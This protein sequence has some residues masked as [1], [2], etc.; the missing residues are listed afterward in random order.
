MVKRITSFDVARDAGVSRTT[1][2]L[3]LNHVENISINPATR[4]RVI[5]AAEKLNYHPNASGRRLVTG[6]SSTI[7]LVLHQSSDQIF[8]DAFLL[9]VMVGVEQA[10]AKHGY[11]VLLKPLDPAQTYDFP[12][13]INENHVDGILLSGP[14]QDD[15]EIIKHN[16]EGFPIMLMG[17]LAGSGIPF[18]DI[19]AIHGAI[20]A[21]RHL[22]NLG[23]R[24]IGLIT[25]AP[26]EYTS[27]QQRR[28]GFIEA[29]LEANIQPND[30]LIREGAFTP[31]SG[32]EAMTELL[33]SSE[34][35][36]AVFVTSDVVAIGAMQAIKKAHKRIPQ[37]IALV[38][39][40][41]IPMAAYFDPPLTTVRLPAYQLGWTAGERL[42][43]LILGEK[44]TE[45]GIFLDTELVIRT[46]T[47]GNPRGK[48]K[49]HPFKNLS[50]RR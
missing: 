28:Q 41:D 39:F 6:K 29:L 13:L 16:N 10:V 48:P 35:P 23:H 38:G 37:D 49:S 47:I 44:L 5:A 2:S 11:H 32:F 27:A 15:F 8:A 30:H 4:Q 7:G 18:V 22:I 12:Q 40:D 36:T 34:L 9:Q 31:A 24:H 17:Q 14:R 45:P 33:Q 3:V 26:L 25:N 43:R 42:V 20:S 19:N 1:V 46:S 21:T 50:Q